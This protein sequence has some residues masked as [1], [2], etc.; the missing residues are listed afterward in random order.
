MV[1]IL[2][3]PQD[4]TRVQTRDLVEYQ[5]PDD[6]KLQAAMMGMT[7][8][9]YLNFQAQQQQGPG[10]I[11]DGSNP[12]PFIAKVSRNPQ[13]Q[14]KVAAGKEKA[15]QEALKTVNGVLEATLPS[16]WI[17]FGLKANG[18]EEMS[19]AASLAV[20]FAP[21]ILGL[22][23]SAAKR[24]APRVFASSNDLFK[25]APE[26]KKFI[27]DNPSLNPYSQ[28]ALDKF[29]EIQGRST[30][31]VYNESEKAA[32]DA[33][34]NISK[35]DVKYNPGLD[36]Q[37]SNGG[38]YTSNSKD[39]AKQFSIKRHANPDDNLVSVVGDLN[40]AFNIDRSLPLADQMKQ[41]KKG[42]QFFSDKHVFSL[43]FD[44]Q[45]MVQRKFKPNAVAIEAPYGEGSNPFISKFRSHIPK[46][47]RIYIRGNDPIPSNV[48]TRIGVG[49]SERQSG[50]RS[51][52]PIT[53]GS[54]F[55]PY[56]FGSLPVDRVSKTL[57]YLRPLKLPAIMSASVIPMRYVGEFLDDA[58]SNIVATPK[59]TKN[60]E[61]NKPS[62]NESDNLAIADAYKYG[63]KINYLNRYK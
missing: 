28:E 34:T 49:G 13:E 50:F 48:E 45:D 38:L 23:F 2:E 59:Y 35:K 31:G 24:V 62:N 4:N 3:I 5:I 20:D 42:I 63:G 51:K 39:V 19:D 56:E 57:T 32:L 8:E 58:F 52:V 6:I 30:R 14:A 60:D 46:H 53:S 44:F 40:Y 16:T 33:L 10:V 27:K 15:K 43:P 12:Q 22:G 21:A 47:E 26:Y 25:I 1:E 18:K 54:Y 29:F 7:V 41:Y 61:G 9:E 11:V 36:A 17:N 55:Y 37:A